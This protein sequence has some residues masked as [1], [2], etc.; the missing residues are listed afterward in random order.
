MSQGPHRKI[1]FSLRFKYGYYQFFD[2]FLD[3]I[4]FFV[5]LEKAE[6]DFIKS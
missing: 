4:V 2:H 1:S 6:V 3:A 5:G